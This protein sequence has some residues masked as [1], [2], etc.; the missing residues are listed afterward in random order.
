MPVA[1]RLAGVGLRALAPLSLP[2]AATAADAVF[3]RTSRRPPR[4][5]EAAFLAEARADSIRWNGHRIRTWRWPGSGP[6]LLLAHGWCSHPGRFAAWG[7]VARAAGAELVAFDAPG[8]GQSTGWRASMPEIARALRAVADS[9]G[10]CD[11]VIGHSVGGAAALFALTQGL[12]IPRLVTLAA[13]AEVSA[14]LDR[15]IAALRL[16][17]AVGQALRQRLLHRLG[18]TLDELDLPR[19]VATL[20]TRA[21][22]VHDSDDSDVPPAAATAL[23]RNWPSAEV[24][25]TR[26]LG[27][28]ALLRDPTVIARTVGFAAGDQN[29]L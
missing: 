8:H 16:P 3:S 9:V 13:P 24:W 10:R 1:L 19:R 2:L 26:G 7:R 21:L 11:A 29:G 20:P 12:A 14:W 17:E 15:F 28:R 6:R 27:H 22:L 23:A 5:D 25:L 4:D 18:V